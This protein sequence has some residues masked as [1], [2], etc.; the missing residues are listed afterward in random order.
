MYQLVLWGRRVCIKLQMIS[1]EQAG[2]GDW[3]KNICVISLQ[4]TTGMSSLPPSTCSARHQ[5]LSLWDIIWGGSHILMCWFISYVLHKHSLNIFSALNNDLC[6]SIIQDLFLLPS[7]WKWSVVSTDPAFPVLCVCLSAWFSSHLCSRQGSEP[8][9]RIS[10]F[11]LGVFQMAD[12][13][14][15]QS[16]LLWK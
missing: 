13:S 3:R 15:L 7:E 11:S 2:P 6:W 14:N 16:F 4:L 5:Q 12:L 1:P 8:A 10:R 9:D